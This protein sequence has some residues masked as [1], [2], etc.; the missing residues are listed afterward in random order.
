M[1]YLFTVNSGSNTFSMFFIEKHDPQHPTLV[2]SPASTM[3]EFPQTL[4]YSPHL[5]I[6]PL[7]LPRTSSIH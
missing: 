3:G 7:S 5:K 4:A 1:Q 6:G 2:G